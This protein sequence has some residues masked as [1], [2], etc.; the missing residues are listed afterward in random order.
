MLY[1]VC[2]MWYVVCGM[3]YVVCGMFCLP[4]YVLSYTPSY[5]VC[6]S[7]SCSSNSSSS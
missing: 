4:M 1:V 3:L 2:C 6:G 7:S 5:V